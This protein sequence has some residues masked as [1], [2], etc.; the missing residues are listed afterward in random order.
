MKQLCISNSITRRDITSLNL[1][2]KDISKEGMIT[3]EEEITLAQQIHQGNRE[4]LNKLVTANLRFV[5][6]IAKQ[7]QNRGLELPDLINEGNL[8]LV[9]AANKYDETKGFK[10]ISYAVW[11]IRQYILQ[12]IFNQSKSVRLPFN[13]ITNINKLNRLSAEFEQT[14]QR[15]PS[16]SELA[17][18]MGLPE[19][20]IVETLSVTNNCVS[21]DTPFSDEEDGT[22]VDV[23]PNSNAEP[24]DAKLME[25]SS[26]EE[27]LIILGKLKPREHDII[28]MSFGIGMQE[29]S[30][31]EIGKKFGLTGERIRQINKATL[32]KL[33]DRYGNELSSLLK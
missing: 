21:I 9:H 3:P 33:K 30:Y 11:W 18:L 2:L 29:Q 15:K 10:F 4:A 7:Y 6:S 8:G 14:N 22:L 25:D 24:T 32:K 31:E 20:K 17:D 27:L 16:I 28:R 23:L 1:Y 13:Q 26:S 12:A 19:E 5:V